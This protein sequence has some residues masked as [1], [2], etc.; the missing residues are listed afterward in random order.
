M[1]FL[2]VVWEGEGS[3]LDIHCNINALENGSSF[4]WVAVPLHILGWR[5]PQM[6]LEPKKPL[7][8]PLY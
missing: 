5:G 2:D 7:G 6:E 8:V 1:V 4:I 3:F